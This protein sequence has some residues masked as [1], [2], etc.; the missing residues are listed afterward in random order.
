MTPHG[1]SKGLMLTLAVLSLSQCQRPQSQL[2]PPLNPALQG[3]R[4]FQGQSSVNV[5]EQDLKTF[6]RH[7]FNPQQPIP[8]FSKIPAPPDNP[9]TQAK[10]ELGFRLFMEPALSANNQMSC[11]TCHAPKTGFSNAQP[12]AMGVTGHHGRR[13]VPTTYGS[14]YITRSFWDGRA[15]TL[16]EQALMP[17]QDPVEMNE[18]L[19][20]VIQKLQNI[21]Y[22][23]RKFK[24]VFGTPVQAEG[25]AKAL[26]SFQ[27]AL[28]LAPTPYERYQQGEDNAMTPLQKQGF[29]VFLSSRCFGCHRGP[30]FS[31]Q[32]FV[33]I[34]LG[35]DKPNPDLGRY[36]I[37]KRESDWG[38]FKIPT[39]LNVEKSAPYM[40]D[41]SL[42]TLRDVIEFYNKGGVDNK[43]L[44]GRIM[45]LNLSEPNKQALEA[46]LQALSA[47]DNFTVLANLPG[48]R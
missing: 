26:A 25:M 13:N 1:F 32:G 33:N 20:N 7:V 23:N 11:A 37:T 30:A 34:G 2:Y 38:M 5:T 35:L 19:P 10:V 46:F 14:A 39:L 43:N 22:Y 8:D 4:Q 16:E 29:N 9:V 44:D 36:E 41:G 27:R 47:E 28:T 3:Q 18:T 15:R 21:D 12:T 6:G 42:K 40:H 48:V 31:S 45:P 17:I 24:A